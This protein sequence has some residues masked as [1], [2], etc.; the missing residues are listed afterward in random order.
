[1]NYCRLR[2]LKLCIIP[3]FPVAFQSAVT[4]LLWPAEH[5]IVYGL[6]DGKVRLQHDSPLRFVCGIVT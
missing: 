1:M 6:V 4:C 3:F 2:P 5:A